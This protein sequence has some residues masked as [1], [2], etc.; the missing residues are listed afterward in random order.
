MNFLD[1]A[2]EILKQIDKPLRYTEITARAQAAKLLSTKGQTPEATMGSRLYVD[3]KRPNSRFQQ[4]SRGVFALKEAPPSEI[5]QRI[6]T[7][8]R[9]TRNDLQKRLLEMTPARFE[10]LI[11]ELLQ[12]LGFEEEKIRVT[13]RSGDGGIDVRGVLNAGNIT[14]INAAVQ[15]KRW[16]NNVHSPIVQALRGSLTVYEQGIIITTSKFSEGAIAEAKAPGKVPI[17]LIDGSKLLDLLIESKIGVV[18]DQYTVYSLDEE[19]W[20]DI[21]PVETKAITSTNELISDVIYP[22]EIQG[23]AHKQLFQALLLDAKGRTKYGELEYKS[24]SRAAM[25]ATGWKTCNGWSFWR[26][27]H[28]ETNDWHSIDELRDKAET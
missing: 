26:Y 19:W 18:S 3:T 7:I 1:A 16:K 6:D 20:S 17:S 10:L 14:E 9:K 2:F 4:I 23:N 22:L 13:G 12:A 5:N 8:N 11:G 25:V 21:V 27:Q 24:P 28:P 15:V